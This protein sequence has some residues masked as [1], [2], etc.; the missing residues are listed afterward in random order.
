MTFQCPI[1]ISEYP[2][3]LLAHGGGGKLT[4]ML[5]ERIFLPAFANPALEPL[6]DGAILEVGGVRLAF[7]TD[8]FV[9][10]PIFFPGGDIGCL[11][12]HGTVNDLAMC[13]ARPLALSAGFILEEGF[14]MEDLCRVVESMKE[15]ASRAGVPIVTG[16]TKVVDRGKGDGVFINT[17]GIGLIPPGIHISP[18]RARPGDLILINGAIAVHGIAIM[19]VREGLEFETTLL[20]DTAPLHDLVARILE[21]G[22]DRVHVL[23][24]PTRGGL[25]SALNEIASRARV[26]ILLDEASIPIWEEVKGACEILGL[27]PLYVANEGKCLVIVARDKAEEVL[28]AMRAHPLGQEAA[29]IGEVVEEHPGQVILRSRI[30][31]MRVVDML[32]GEQLPRIC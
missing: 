25:A 21:V 5:I 24:D 12:V 18:K 8:S 4:H 6:H 29:I 17:T 1:P 27:D 28:E 30:G 15:A 14:P 2:T 11:A 22:G 10:S 3:V 26:G 9:V 16:D 31:G 19:S 13:G 20:S 23:R 7:T 32:S